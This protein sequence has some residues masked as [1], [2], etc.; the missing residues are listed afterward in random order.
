MRFDDPAPGVL[1]AGTYA[2]GPQVGISLIVYFYGDDAET[3]AA[4]GTERWREWLGALA[5]PASI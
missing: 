2:V 5:V 4:A 1:L 3:R